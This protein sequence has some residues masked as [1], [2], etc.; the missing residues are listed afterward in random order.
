M[1]TRPVSYTHLDVY[2]RQPP[3]VR[4]AAADGT[5]STCDSTLAIRLVTSNILL[6]GT[7]PQGQVNIPP[8]CLTCILS[9]RWKNSLFI[10]FL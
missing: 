7:M 2:K 9:L 8:V 10:L 5:E 6:T 3:A 1:E 4:A